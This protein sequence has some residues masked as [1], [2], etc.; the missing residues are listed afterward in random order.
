VEHL[1]GDRP[2]EAGIARTVDLAHA[3][4]TKGLDDFV[5]PELRTRPQRHMRAIIRKQPGEGEHTLAETLR[6]TWEGLVTFCR[7]AVQ[8]AKS[9]GT[10]S[11]RGVQAGRLR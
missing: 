6:N 9:A 8:N 11:W 3:P 4:S 10:E 7:C 2:V 5:R 1:D